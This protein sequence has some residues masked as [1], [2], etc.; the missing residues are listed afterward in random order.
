MQSKKC[1]LRCAPL[2]AVPL[3][4]MAATMPAFGQNCL[5]DEYTAGGDTQTL[6]CTANDVQLAAVKNVNVLDN[7]GNPTN[8]N[9]CLAGTQ[10]SFIADFEIV[11]TAKQSRSNIG[12]YFGTGTGST[13]NGALSGVCTDS[14]IAPLHTCAAGSSLTCGSDNYHELDGSP[15]NC[16]DTSS[17]DSSTTY[18]SGAQGV[19]I[20]VDNVTCPTTGNSV[21]LPECTSWQIP[22]KTI[23]C[24]SP[25]PYY[26]YEPAAIPGSPSKCSCGVL[27]IPVQPIHPGVTVAKSCNTTLTTDPGKTSCDAG[28]EGSTVTYTV[29]ITNAS[30]NGDVVVDQ[31]CDDQYGT[32][33]DDGTIKTACPAGKLGSIVSGSA[34]SCASLGTISTSAPCT[35]QAVQGEIASVTD[36]VTVS[37][38]SS[39]VTSN[40]FGP[41]SSNTV[42]VTSSDA[43]TT[44]TTNKGLAPGPVQACLTL[45]FNVNVAN[46]SSADET[47]SLGPT[48]TYGAAGYVPA[49]NDS[50]FGDVSHTHGNSSTAGS[51]TGTT[52]GVAGGAAGTGTLSGTTV[53]DCQGGT[54]SSCNGGAYT[55]SL[56][57]GTGTPPTSN[58][59]YY[60]CQFD[61]VIC[62]TPGSIPNVCSY[63]LTNTDT[64]TANLTGDDAAPNADTIT[65]T[66]NPFIA[67]VCLN[68]Q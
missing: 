19:L 27:S 59:G 55:Q 36:T 44:A 42:T 66:E 45:R 13:Q 64:V 60:K 68:Q 38:H 41:T 9:K 67:N 46:T 29:D 14:I 39:L 1:Y 4:M 22:G 12:V 53:V 35:F 58:G 54:I 43:P 47:V 7:N 8:D 16:G 40:L 23:Q 2:L 17:T 11:T 26:P 61:G 48:G 34:S 56:A 10:F 24:I 21:S 6:N 50:Y 28:P 5:Q 18:G 30:D 52:C 3:L 51:V 32:V 20:E 31:I 15:D 25:S 57:P 49:L 33:Y 63:G 65:Q 62:G 37:G